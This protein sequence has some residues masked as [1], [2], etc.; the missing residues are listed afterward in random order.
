MSH[1]PN[2]TVTNLQKRK[3]NTITKLGKVIKG[4]NLKISLIFFNEK[5]NN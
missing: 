5:K 4:I 3:K 2:L 1:S